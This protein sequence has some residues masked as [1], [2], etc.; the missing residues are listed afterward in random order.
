MRA[1]IAILFLLGAAAAVPA[2]SEAFHRA[3]ADRHSVLPP[4]PRAVLRDVQRAEAAYRASHGRYTASLAALG[5]GRPPGVGVRITAQGGDGYSA[6]AIAD[7]E[8]CAVYHGRARP[9]RN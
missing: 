6:V 4:H 9:P 8:E 7:D 2:A 3:A 5:I 1:L